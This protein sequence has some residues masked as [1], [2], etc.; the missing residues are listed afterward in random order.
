M[1]R[2]GGGGN[3]LKYKKG[4]VHAAKDQNQIRPSSGKTNQPRSIHTKFYSCDWLIQSII[5]FISEEQ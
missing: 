1:R 3:K 4:G 5:N 2:G